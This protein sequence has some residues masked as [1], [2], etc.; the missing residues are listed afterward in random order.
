M[1]PAIDTNESI[2]AYIVYL[3]VIYCADVSIFTIDA[4]VNFFF[5]RSLKILMVLISWPTC[6]LI[7]IY[8]GIYG[9]TLKG[10]ES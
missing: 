10:M 9:N 6:R 8:G 3:L 2:M 1:R 5:S 4:K 7:L